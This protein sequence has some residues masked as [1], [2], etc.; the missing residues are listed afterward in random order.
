MPGNTDANNPFTFQNPPI[1]EKPP[2]TTAGTIRPASS[3]T[4]LNRKDPSKRPKALTLEQY[5]A[6]DIELPPSP[7]RTKSN[8]NVLL[9]ANTLAHLHTDQPPLPSPNSANARMTSIAHTAQP[10]MADT[11]TPVTH[12]TTATHMAVGQSSTGQTN[13]LPEP[14]Q[15]PSPQ[16]RPETIPGAIR[17]RLITH[18]GPKWFTIHGQSQDRLLK[19]IA[20]N[21]RR[22]WLT[23]AGF[24]V[25][26][27]VSRLKV[28]RNPAERVAAMM[29]IESTLNLVFPGIAAIDVCIGD[30]IG[31]HVHPNSAYPFLIQGLTESQA[32]LLTSE[33]CLATDAA[34]TFFY[35]YNTP[36]PITDYAFSL[37]GLVLTPSPNNDLRAATELVRFL[38]VAGEFV[39]FI[40]IHHDNIPFEAESNP[41]N[42]VRWTL[43]TLR[44]TSSLV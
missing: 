14:T 19:P 42:F 23:L 2:A 39:Q 9:G 26:A 13:H 30:T 6:E 11:T 44:V 38:S 15:P 43:T 40:T 20:L 22:D 8:K 35:P 17:S 21:H 27:V 36:L 4:P 29:A 33:F 3:R 41:S 25:L 12:D 1:A 10:I 18:P 37:E 7:T 34:A 32:L 16:A 24:K 5:L 31:D 28:T